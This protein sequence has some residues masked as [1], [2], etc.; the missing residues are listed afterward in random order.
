LPVIRQTAD[1]VQEVAEASREQATGVV[2]IN[3]AMAQVDEVTQR[4]AAAAEELAST[5][6]ELATQAQAL[7]TTMDF[8][9]VGR[10]GPSI[11]GT[12][13]G[14]AARAGNGAS[15]RTAPIAA[16]V[17]TNGVGTAREAPRDEEFER[18]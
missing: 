17:G 10:R 4:N 18:F 3:K 14:A 12:R 5:A 2:Q 16:V 8:F 9:H 1:L 7:R 11:D 15:G 13:A 6:E